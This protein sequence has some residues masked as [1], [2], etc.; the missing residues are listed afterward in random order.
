MATPTSKIPA[1]AKPRIGLVLSCGGLRGA[2]HLGV[3]KQLN[4]H[5][6]P[7]DV[8]V[9]VSAGA[10]IAGFYAAAG[11]TAEDMI[12]D[13]PTFR[14]RH[15]VFQGLS[16]RVP[17]SLKPF[18]LRQAG[19]VPTRLAQLDA[20]RFD[21]LYHGV[22]RLGIVCHDV[23]GNRPLY[24]ST[25]RHYEV[26]VAQVV[27]GSAAVPVLLPTTVVTIN[28][29]RTRLTDGGITDSLPIAF[30]RSED[31]GATHL[32]VSDCRVYGRPTREDEAAPDIVNI[33]P[34]LT[35][36]GSFRSPRTTLMA[37]VHAGESAVTEQHVTAIRAWLKNTR[38]S[39]QV[40]GL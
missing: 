17:S 11:L 20:A 1:N 32:I 39:L 6:I 28:G 2:A 25:L 13:A 21:K 12:G 34:E 16:A 33:R 31:L 5:K 24:F 8:I 19:V 23:M 27:K 30:A 38:P 37:A 18:L 35:G 36:I 29:K 4:R 14:G 15:V 9:G 7:I 40:V 26:T 10:V 22:Q 3:L